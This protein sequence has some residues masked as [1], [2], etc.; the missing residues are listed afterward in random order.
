MPKR[1]RPPIP[2][3]GALAAAALVLLA[4]EPLLAGTTTPTGTN[5]WQTAVNNVQTALTG[6]VGRGLSLIAIA[7]SGFMFAFGEP[8]AK[9]MVAGVVFGVAMILGAANWLTWLGF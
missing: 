5:P 1:P 6:P 3:S 2:H 8:G 4:A 7:I 9:K